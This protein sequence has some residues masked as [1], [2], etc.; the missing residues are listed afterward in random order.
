M[1]FMLGIFKG[2]KTSH[3][4]FILDRTILATRLHENPH[5]C[6]HH[7]RSSLTLVGTKS[8]LGRSFEDRMELTV[9][10]HWV[11]YTRRTVF[12]RIK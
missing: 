4:N 1:K 9:Q 5:A 6:L 11:F 10:V 2:K 12:V 8:A 7:E 3:L